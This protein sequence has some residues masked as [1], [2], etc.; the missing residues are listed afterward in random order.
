MDEAMADSEIEKLLAE[1]E[2]SDALDILFSDTNNQEDSHGELTE[3]IPEHQDLLDEMVKSMENGS[4]LNFM[5]KVTGV[6][7][8]AHTVQLVINDALKKLSKTH[9]NII[10]LCRRVTR[11]LHLKSTQYE[12]EEKNMTYCQPRFDVNTRW[13][14]TYLMVNTH[15]TFKLHYTYD[16]FFL[17]II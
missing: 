8:T 9:Y 17:T 14:S 4:E 15:F 13:S 2:V 3:A 1:K 16:F 7:C 10:D 6:H 11:H 5:W 12:V